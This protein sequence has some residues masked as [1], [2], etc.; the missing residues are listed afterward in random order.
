MSSE[1]FYLL[2]CFSKYLSALGWAFLFW[3]TFQRSDWKKFSFLFH[4]CS[5]AVMTLV[6]SSICSKLFQKLFKNLLVNVL[7]LLWPL[8]ELELWFVNKDTMKTLQQYEDWDTYFK[9][10]T[11]YFSQK[12]N[13][14]NPNLIHGLSMLRLFYRGWFVQHLS[15]T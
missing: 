10:L 8:H 2:P 15:P 7:S 9:K 14:S 11:C 4:C 6:P 1:F 5:V 3:K 13:D 12:I